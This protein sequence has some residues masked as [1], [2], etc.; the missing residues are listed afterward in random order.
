M[1]I[2]LHKFGMIFAIINKCTERQICLHMLVF[3]KLNDYLSRD[4]E[5]I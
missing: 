4:I 1:N 5:E 2:D 3:I